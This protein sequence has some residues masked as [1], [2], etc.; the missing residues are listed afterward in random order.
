MTD[1]KNLMSIIE[2]V[3]RF[4]Q[5]MNDNQLVLMYTDVITSQT[6]QNLTAITE[7]K[8]SAQN[9]ENRVKKKVFNVMMECIQNITRH[10]QKDHK[11]TMSS[12]FILGKDQEERFFVISG[13]N[14]SKK[15]REPLQSRLDHLNDLDADQLH[16]HYLEV[17]DNGEISERGGAGLGFI[18]I[19]RKSKSKIEYH[20]HPVEDED[21]L[22]FIFKVNI[23]N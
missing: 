23:E 18:D 13:N 19:L 8:L 12:V 16:E 20:F 22:F 2:D 9:T 14:I 15:D 17:I 7:D 1:P 21:A 6:L 11:S 4:K 10:G 5:L 3:Y